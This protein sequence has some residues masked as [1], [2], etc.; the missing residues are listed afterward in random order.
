[1]YCLMWALVGCNHP[2]PGKDGEGASPF[3]QRFPFTKAEGVDRFLFLVIVFVFVI[4][5]VIVSVSFSVL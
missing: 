3:C 1:M 2:L 4:V 5:I